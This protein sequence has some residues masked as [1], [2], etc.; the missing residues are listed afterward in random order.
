MSKSQFSVAMLLSLVATI[1]TLTACGGGGGEGSDTTA[2]TGPSAEGVYSGTLTG[3]SSNAFNLL[4]LE[5]GDYWSMYGTQVGTVFGVAG[6]IQGT[7]SS[8]NGSFTS[9]NGKDFGVSPA[10]SG[11]VNATYNATAKTI[12]GTTTS[13]SGTS[14]FNGGPITGSLYN[15][16][17]AATLSTIVGSWTTTSLTGETVTI[18]IAADGTFTAVSNGGCNFSG[19]FAPRASGKNVFNTS[20]TF[21]VVPCELPNQTATGIA[22]AYPLTTGQTQLIVAGTDAARTVGAAVIGTR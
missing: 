17:T 6:F 2:V 10:V 7:G 8:S 20:L 21:G 3:S 15:Y 11:V 18:S 1:S 12:N 22:V 9:A 5:N 14:T 13:T 16:D 19:T 4:I